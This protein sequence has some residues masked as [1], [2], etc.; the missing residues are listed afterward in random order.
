MQKI[1]TLFQREIVGHTVTAIYPKVY[2]GMGW[3]LE[4]EGDATIKFDGACCMIHDGKFFKRY[5]AKR[6]KTPPPQAIPCCPPDPVTGHWPHWVEC[7]RDNPA[8]RWLWAAYDTSPECRAEGTYEAIGKHFQGNPY[9]LQVD[10]L[11]PHGKDVVNVVRTFEG[12]RTYLK[13]VPVEGLVFW[14]DG[15]PQCKIKRRDFGFLWPCP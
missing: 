7:N 11:V 13:E 12:I 15:K 10:I 4:G 1:P 14:K 2:P 3:V 9:G 6:G 8:E 5:D